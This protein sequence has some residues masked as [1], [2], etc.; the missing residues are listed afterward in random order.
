MTSRNCSGCG[1]LLDRDGSCFRCRASVGTD[2]PGDA[3]T[4]ARAVYLEWFGE[5]Y[6]LGALDTVLCAAAAQKLSGDPAWVLVV[7]GSGT[8]KTETIAPLAAAGAHM[9]STI[10]GEAALLSATPQERRSKQAHGGL[11]KSMG[12]SGLV[13]IKD[14]TSILSM[15]RDTRASVLA[16][17]RD[18]YDGHWTRHVGTDGGLTFAW[19]GRIV[20]IGAVTTAWDA[21]HQ[22]VATMGDRFVLVRYRGDER[23]AAGLQAIRNI[24]REDGMRSDLADAVKLV[25]AEAADRPEP[26]VDDGA[27]GELLDL[28]DLVTRCRTPV[29]RDFQGNPAFAHALEMPTRFTKQLVQ[30]VRGGLALGMSQ[31]RAM[32]VA[33]RAA[34]DSMPPQRLAVLADVA[35]H[36][37]SRTADVARRLRMPWR[38]ADRALQ[39]LQLLGCLIVDEDHQDKWI[40]SVDP[41]VA[42][43][44]KS[45]ARKV[46]TTLRE[47]L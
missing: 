25:L 12:K 19:R 1:T 37:V 4:Q 17:L 5:H 6:D 23:R 45:I 44:A 7:G 22:V 18:I 29:E 3:L 24:S 46:T 16:A 20:V 15:H 34:R 21:H 30:L 28:A 14:F 10:T 38:S 40:Y 35:E 43:V 31:D 11:L 9:V 8:A 26:V 13:V 27:V 47:D 39:E 2:F 36:A 32:A 33:G 41:S 42:D